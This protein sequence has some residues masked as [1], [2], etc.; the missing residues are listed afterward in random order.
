MYNKEIPFAKTAYEHY[1]A[2]AIKGTIVE[3][4]RILARREAGFTTSLLLF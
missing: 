1:S 3:T 2:R 4:A